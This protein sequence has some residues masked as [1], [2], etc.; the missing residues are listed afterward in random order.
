MPDDRPAIE[1]DHAT[2]RYGDTVALDD[3]TMR[4]AP[5][6]FYCLLGPSGSSLT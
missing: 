2:K 1:L 6:E 3:V 5:G 4:I